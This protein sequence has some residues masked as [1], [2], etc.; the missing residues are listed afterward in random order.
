MVGLGRKG[1][2]ELDCPFCHKGRIKTFHKEGY[3]QARTSRISAGAKT[4]YY[5]KQDIYE[6]LEDCAVCG[7]KKKDVQDMYEG[8]RKLSHEERIELWKKRGLPLVLKT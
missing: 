7:A 4:K 1:E 5:T 6:V 2:V 3:F 8:K